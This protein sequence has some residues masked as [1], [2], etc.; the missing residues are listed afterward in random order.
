MTTKLRKS[1]PHTI[2]LLSIQCEML[3]DG[4]S[5]QEA[6]GQLHGLLSVKEDRY[7]PEHPETLKIMVIYATVCFAQ[8]RIAEGSAMIRLVH[9]VRER[10]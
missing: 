7:G 8:G 1:H 6:D 4:G 9:Q 10:S 2:T 3:V 5:F